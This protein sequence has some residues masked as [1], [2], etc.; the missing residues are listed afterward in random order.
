MKHSRALFL[1][2]IL[3]VTAGTGVSQPPHEEWVATYDEPQSGDDE[4][5]AIAPVFVR[6]RWSAWLR[7]STSADW[8]RK[9]S[10]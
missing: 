5:Y 6:F 7:V 2:C 9:Q 8:K 4:S 10:P 1:M 3:L